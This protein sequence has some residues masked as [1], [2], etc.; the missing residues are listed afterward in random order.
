MIKIVLIDDA[1]DAID[2]L[3]E[4]LGKWNQNENFDIIKCANFSNAMK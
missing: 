2:R 1:N 3:K 4:S